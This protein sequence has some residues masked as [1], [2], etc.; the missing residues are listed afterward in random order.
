MIA[1][2]HNSIMGHHGVERTLQRLRAQF[3]KESAEWLYQ[4][5]HVRHF[6]NKCPCCQK[7]SHLK[8]S[9]HTL[10]FTTA[11][12]APWHRINIDTIGPLPAD[13]N[14]NR[15]IIVII[16][17][18]TRYVELYPVKSVDAEHAVLAINAHCG[19]YG[20][21][22][23]IVSDGGTQ[24]INNLMAEY[25]LLTQMEHIQTMA[26]SKEENAIVER[27]NKEVMRHLRAML[28]EKRLCEHWHKYLPFVMRII[29]TTVHSSTGVSPAALLYGNALHK[30]KTIFDN[31]TSEQLTKASLSEWSDKMLHA[32]QILIGIAQKHQRQKDKEHMS[33]T[34]PHNKLTSFPIN[35]YVLV[36]YPS[37]GFKKGPP[38]KL[39]PILKGPMRV[40]NKVG[41]KYT[42]LNLVNNKTEEVHITRLHSFDYDPDHTEPEDIAKRDNQMEDVDHIVK[43]WGNP[44]KKSNMQFLVR[45]ANSNENEDQWLPWKDLRGNIALH[46]YLHERGLDKLIPSEFK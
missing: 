36:E 39:M 35:S 38:N 44:K 28:F 25:C 13:E 2:V 9:I 18:F 16:D 12:Y 29:N 8:T 30:D 27:A 41:V 31:F 1:S 46:K 14:D 20:V 4:R 23:Q 6:I 32:Q 15:Y 34:S 3:P 42:L 7:M 33:L 24:F 43:H 17:T 19:R 26:Y 37:T 21:P 10:P 40:V 22:Q 11:T 45:W 5:E